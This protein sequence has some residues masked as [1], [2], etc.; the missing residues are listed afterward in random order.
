MFDAKL[1]SVLLLEDDPVQAMGI[2]AAIHGISG[3]V[4]NYDNTVDAIDKFTRS[5]FDLCLVDLG[6]YVEGYCHEAH[7][8]LRFIREIRADGHSATPILVATHD[9]K[10]ETLLP[11][12]QAGTD[13]YVL[14]SEGVDKIAERVDAWIKKL[15]CDPEAL[16]KQRSQVIEFL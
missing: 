6:V 15:P 10:S 2:V 5:P 11:C 14:K 16:V 13:D 1:P 8:G 4:S 9:T 12:F 7:G 3:E